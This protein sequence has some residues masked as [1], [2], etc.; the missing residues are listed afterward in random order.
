MYMF[1][2]FLHSYSVYGVCRYYYLL[3]QGTEYLSL[4]SSC[5]SSLFKIFRY[6]GSGYRKF[7]VNT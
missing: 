5:V 4:F 3:V 6:I 1:V 7:T 2:T